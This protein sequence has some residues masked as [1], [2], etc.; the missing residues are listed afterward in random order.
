M[1][2]LWLFDGS[3][4]LSP[5]EIL[6][7]MCVHADTHTHTHHWF[8]WFASHFRGSI[9]LLNLTPVSEWEP[10]PLAIWKAFSSLAFAKG[11][12]L[13]LL[14]MCMREL[15]SPPPTNLTP[16]LL[17]QKLVI[18]QFPAWNG[19]LFQGA[20]SS[21]IRRAEDKG[22]SSTLDVE[23]P[24][25]RAGANSLHLQSEFSFLIPKLVLI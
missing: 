9:A 8:H 10:P 24:A 7:R 13:L 20:G 18:L 14:T 25:E 15:L 6:K 11:K 5:G 21:G 1:Q 23:T 12:E 16:C 17:L 2:P 3:H 4:G 22:L 19:F